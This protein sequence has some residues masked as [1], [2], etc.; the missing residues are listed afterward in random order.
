MEAI[1]RLWRLLHLLFFYYFVYIFVVTFSAAKDHIKR[2]ETD[3]LAGHWWRQTAS[4]VDFNDQDKKTCLPKSVRGKHE[5]KITTIQDTRKKNDLKFLVKIKRGKIRTKG[6]GWV[7]VIW[8]KKG[9]R[10]L[11]GQVY[12]YRYVQKLTWFN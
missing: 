8:S 12:Q 4:Q 2:Q 6:I 11:K 7:A 1:G 5:S 9:V 3:C 10:Y